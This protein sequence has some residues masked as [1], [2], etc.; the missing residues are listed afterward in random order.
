M[1][2]L[3]RTQGWVVFHRSYNNVWLRSHGIFVQIIPNVKAVKI[4]FVSLSSK[5]INN[6][7]LITFKGGLDPHINTCLLNTILVTETSSDLKLIQFWLNCAWNSIQF[8][9][10]PNPEFFHYLLKLYFTNCVVNVLIVMLS[11]ASIKA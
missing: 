8:G 6:Q 5:I 1:Q 2:F 7:Q 11:K 4:L 3:N 10:D 9:A